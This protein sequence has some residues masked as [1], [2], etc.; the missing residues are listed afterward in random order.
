MIPLVTDTFF[1]FADKNESVAEE[2]HEYDLFL[3]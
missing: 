3:W 1:V 2:N